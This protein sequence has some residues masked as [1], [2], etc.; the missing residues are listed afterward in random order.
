MRALSFVSLIALAACQPAPAVE[1]VVKE[2]PV[3]QAEAMPAPAPVTFT[4]LSDLAKSVT[5]D[6]TL[7]VKPRPDPGVAPTMVLETA[8]GVL[9]ET[10]LMPGAAEQATTVDWKKL[11]GG[12]VVV[13]ANPP[14]GSPSV[15]MHDVTLETVPKEASKGGFCGK[16]ATAF[17]AMAAGLQ[18]GDDYTIEIAAFGGDT[19]PPE[20]APKV[21]GVFTYLPPKN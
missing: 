8:T 9:F 15:D 21:C 11:F 12:D 5:G 20:G 7:S 2:E 17:I 19:W 13:T 10:E 6:I 14:P 4:A 16:D 18:Q 3:A 1:E